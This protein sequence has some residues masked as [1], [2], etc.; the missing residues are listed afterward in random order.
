MKLRSHFASPRYI[1]VLPAWRWSRDKQWPRSRSRS[2]DLHC[3]L[4]IWEKLQS[5][6]KRRRRRSHKWKARKTSDRPTVFVHSVQSKSPRR[7]FRIDRHFKHVPFSCARE[8]YTYSVLSDAGRAAVGRYIIRTTT[9]QISRNSYIHNLTAIW[10]QIKYR[11]VDTN[12]MCSLCAQWIFSFRKLLKNVFIPG[13][14]FLTW[15][16]FLTLSGVLL[17]FFAYVALNLLFLHYITMH[18][19][20]EWLADQFCQRRSLQISTIKNT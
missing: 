7:T 2:L 1:Y 10:P 17:A 5:A 14:V 20:A 9:P 12:S 13:C 3:T 11:H 15:I 6:P 4:R 19:T 16:R 8:R 18:Y